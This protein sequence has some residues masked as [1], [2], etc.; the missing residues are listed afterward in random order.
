MSSYMEMA[1]EEER[2]EWKREGSMEIIL[3]EYHNGDLSAEKAAMYLNLS[4]EEF[5]R[6]AQSESKN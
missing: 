2:K 6:L 5:F 3:F 4:V 1:T